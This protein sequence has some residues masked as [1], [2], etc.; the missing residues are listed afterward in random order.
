[1]HLQ[2]EGSNRFAGSL[3]RA[4]SGSVSGSR[5]HLVRKGKQRVARTIDRTSRWAFPLVYF[6][7]LAGVSRWYG[8]I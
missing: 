3:R 8:I 1:L 2:S 7:L 4:S 6:L 5:H